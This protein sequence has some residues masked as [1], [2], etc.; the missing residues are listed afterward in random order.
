MILTFPPGAGSLEWPFL[1][2]CSSSASWRCS[3][4]V[5][6]PTLAASWPATNQQ[7]GRGH[8]KCL[9]DKPSGHPRT[10]ELTTKLFWGPG[11]QISKPKCSRSIFHWNPKEYPPLIGLLK[12]D[13]SFPDNLKEIS[14]QWC[15]FL[16]FIPFSLVV[17][18]FFQRVDRNLK[19]IL[20]RKGPP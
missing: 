18:L 8:P 11:W 1:V 3:L 20:T 16:D 6:L 17:V 13:S 5:Y 4:Q 19:C 14:L 2:C 7:C 12:P 15:A 9:C 10:R